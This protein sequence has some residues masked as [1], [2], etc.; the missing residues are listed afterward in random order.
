MRDWEARTPLGEFARTRDRV[1]IGPAARY[2][3]DVMDEI[4]ENSVDALAVDWL[5]FGGALA[6]EAT[7]TPTAL[8]CHNPYM[9]P[10]PGKPAP[11]MGFGP[12]PGPLGAPR[13]KFGTAVFTRMFDRALPTLNAARSA[14]GLPQLHTVADLFDHVDRVLVLTDEEFDLRPTTRSPRVVHVGPVLDEPAAADFAPLP[15]APSDPRPLVLITSSTYFQDPRRMLVNGC[16]AVRSI[17]AR[18]VVTSGAVDP[19]DLPTG[20]DIIAVHTAPHS[21]ILGHA[22]AAVSHCGLG[23]VHRALVA[24]VPILCQPIGRD[25]P[26]VA[27]RV[28]AA[29]AGLRLGPKTSAKRTAKALTRLIQETSYRHRAKE[30]GSR[31]L[32]SAEG[33]KYVVE[34]EQLGRSHSTRR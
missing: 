4:A 34:L 24:G 15:W 28:V 10:E 8:I 20:E 16:G 7:S 14:L 3:A 19:A 12:L 23:T 6:G 33:E 5:L 18:A 22:N 31:L 1:M 27:A 32:T 2:A 21:V 17:G 11:G 13:D 26:D 29:G 25:Q 9:V 30:V